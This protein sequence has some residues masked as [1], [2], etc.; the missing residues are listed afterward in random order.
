MRVRA[1]LHHRRERPV[2]VA[3][4]RRVIPLQ[5]RRAARAQ[6]LRRVRADAAAE[7]EQLKLFLPSRARASHERVDDARDVRLVPLRRRRAHRD[8]EPL[9]AARHPA[10][11][12]S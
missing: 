7:F 3:H 6:D 8:V 1:I 11:A 10:R 12:A 2:V 4:V 5:A 9:R